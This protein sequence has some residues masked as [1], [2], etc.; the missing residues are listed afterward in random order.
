MLEV[1]CTLRMRK[2]EF[3]TKMYLNFFI[4]CVI[5]FHFREINSQ[6]M[7]N[8]SHFFEKWKNLNYK[9]STTWNINKSFF[10]PRTWAANANNF[11][12]AIIKCLHF[13]HSSKKNLFHVWADDVNRKKMFYIFESVGISSPFVPRAF[14]W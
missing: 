14:W 3:F 6:M 2:V 13:F 9:F 5:N 4:F 7:L 10:F 8:I 1:L 12:Y 11:L